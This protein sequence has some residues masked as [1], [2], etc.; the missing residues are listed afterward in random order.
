MAMKG[1]LEMICLAF[2]AL[3]LVN[4]CNV[5]FPGKASRLKHEVE[6]N[7]LLLAAPL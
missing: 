6:N 5:V 7:L 3:C 1:V 4:L 2:L